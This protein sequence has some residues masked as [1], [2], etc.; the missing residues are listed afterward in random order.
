MSRTASPSVQI[1]P[2]RARHPGSAVG[3]SGLSLSWLRP[4]RPLRRA[5]HPGLHHRLPVRPRQRR[6]GAQRRLG[7]PALFAALA[8]VCARSR[9]GRPAPGP[10]PASCRQTHT[11][12]A[13][14]SKPTAATS[15]LPHQSSR[16]A[17]V[18]CPR[19]PARAGRCMPDRNRPIRQPPAGRLAAAGSS[20]QPGA[21]RDVFGTCCRARLPPSRMLISGFI[22]L[23]KSGNLPIYRSRK[24]GDMY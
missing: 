6:S 2:S 7:P 10:S 8:A 20:T 15:L 16:Q 19:S 5:R 21:S 9:P 22:A 14:S 1:L 12:P 24:I 11:A 13:S 23:P 17:T 3:R 4:G 18:I